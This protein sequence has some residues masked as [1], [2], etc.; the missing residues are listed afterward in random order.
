VATLDARIAAAT[1]PHT[2]LVKILCTI[3]GVGRYIAEC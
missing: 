3:P 2:E 1:Q